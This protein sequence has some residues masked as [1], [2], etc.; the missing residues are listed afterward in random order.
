[1]ALQGC[2]VLGFDT[3][4]TGVSTDQDRI[5]TTALVARAADGTVTERTW[6]ID[7]G[8]EIPPPAQA[9][10]GITTE[11]ARQHGAAPEVA[12]EEIAAAL[13][14]GLAAGVPVLAFN[15]SYDLRII[16]A[17][18]ARRGLPTLAQRLGRPVAP[19]I[20]PLVIDRGVD[21]Y[22]KGKRKLADLMSVYRVAPSDHLHDA[23]EDVRQAIAVFDAIAGAYPEL[24]AMDLAKL[25][26]W[27]AAKH[28][29]WATNF[30]SWLAKQGR[31]A[32]VDPEWP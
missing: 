13:A 11:Y 7:P 21:R 30:N 26:A 14:A 2:P 8:V 31:V 22:R 5:V 28:R 27:Q 9:V 15:A 25:H 6:L 3:E 10:H 12:L 24:N 23:L 16:E 18:L 20:D 19:V 32:D 4:T 1:M 17:D 29:E